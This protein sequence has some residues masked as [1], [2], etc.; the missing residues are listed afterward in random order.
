M[1]DLTFNVVRSENQG[2]RGTMF[3]LKELNALAQSQAMANMDGEGLKGMA[4]D[5]GV[6]KANDFLAD[7][8]IPVDV[9][10]LADVKNM[11]DLKGFA[12]D[13]AMDAGKDAALNFAK[14]KGLDLS[15]REE[16]RFQTR[17]VPESAP[18]P[19]RPSPPALR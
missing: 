9:S 4:K 12:K 6:G 17:V 11:D 7:K 19:P 13:A 2:P 14:E 15:A 10:G 8:G 3:G 18:Q 16:A 1:V 5:A